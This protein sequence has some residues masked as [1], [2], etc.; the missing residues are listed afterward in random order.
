MDKDMRQKCILCEQLKPYVW[1]QSATTFICDS[2]RAD[3]AL[4]R[5]VRR[6]RE[7]M[8]LF[9]HNP[10]WAFRQGYS[11]DIIRRDTPEAALKAAGLWEVEK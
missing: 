8:A 1:H 4:G 7:G 5:S 6:F 10:E 2:C 9:K 3:A 11:G